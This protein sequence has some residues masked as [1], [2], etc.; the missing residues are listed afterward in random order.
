M[1]TYEAEALGGDN[2]AVR[3]YDDDELGRAH[4]CL[5]ATAEMKVPVEGQPIAVALFGDVGGG[6]VRLA[7]TGA[8]ATRA[9]ACVGLGVTYGPLRLDYAFNANRQR[10]VHVGLVA[11][12][13]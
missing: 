6:T 10:R 11:P 12:E 9:G 8:M 2:G 7:T 5:G 3:G 13:D 1:P 4:S